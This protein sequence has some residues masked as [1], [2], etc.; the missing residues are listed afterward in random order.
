MKTDELTF[1]NE[2]SVLR[3]ML[4]LQ[5]RTPHKS[6]WSFSPGFYQEAAMVYFLLDTRGDCPVETFITHTLSRL[7]QQ[8]N[9]HTERHLVEYQGRVRGRIAWAAT[10]KARYSQSGDPGRYVSQ[11]VRHQYDTPQNQL[12]K[13]LVQRLTLGIHALPAVIRQG[14]CY[15]LPETSENLVCTSIAARVVG[16]EMALRHFHRHAH[17]R[18]VTLLPA[19]DES[20]LIRTENLRNPDYADVV[21]IYRHY[22]KV[23][24]TFSQKSFSESDVRM[25]LLPNQIDQTGVPWIGLALQ[26]LNN[27]TPY[28]HI[29][30]IMNPVS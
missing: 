5:M 27:R 14:G 15:I 1:R 10:F 3:R 19:I 6:V 16:M 26:I 24:A 22:H 11:E 30:E 7:L 13:F 28:H 9:R 20:H 17:L 8:L 12:L 18:D 2:P 25:F 21:R 29:E 4:E 23:L